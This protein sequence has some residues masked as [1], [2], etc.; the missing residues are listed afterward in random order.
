MRLPWDR[1]VPVVPQSRPTR[2]LLLAQALDACISAERRL[3]GSAQEII[4]RQPAWA[5]AELQRLLD[6]A[7]SLDAAASNAIMSGEFRAAA[8]ARLMRRIGAEPSA[9]TDTSARRGTNEPGSLCEAPRPSAGQTAAASRPS[10]LETRPATQP[11]LRK[12][13]WLRL[14]A[15]L[16]AAGVVRR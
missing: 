8:R 10:V 3:P 1:G 14:R 5:R 6:L 13:F 4:A 12:T 2:E 11:A 9:V 15:L 16:Q 7:G